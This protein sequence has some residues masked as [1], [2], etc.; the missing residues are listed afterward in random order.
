MK[1]TR[2]VL[3]IMSPAQQSMIDL[4]ERLSKIDGISQVDIALTELEMNIVDFKVTLDGYS[5]D[6]ER[7]RKIIKDFSAII[8]NV[9]YISSAKQRVPHNDDDKLSASMLVLAKHVDSKEGGL[10]QIYSEFDAAL[11]R[12][13][14]TSLI[15]AS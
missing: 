4:A 11:K 7:I 9:D 14:A 10:D 12:I 1:I 15:K 5:L 6:F 13:K 2:I 8:R 3:D